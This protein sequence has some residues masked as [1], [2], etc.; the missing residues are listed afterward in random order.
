MALIIQQLAPSSTLPTDDSALKASMSALKTSI[1][2]LESSINT[3][4]ARSDFWETFGW[5]CAIAVG[6]GVA[7]EIVIIVWDFIEDRHAWRRGIVRAP[8]HPSHVRFWFDIIATAVVII[9]II[10]EAGASG[11]VSSIN[12]Q[13]RSKSSELRAKSD[14]LL[15]LVTQ[16]S[17]DAAKSAHDARLD[18][19]QARYDLAILRSLVSGRQMRPLKGLRLKGKL[20]YVESGDA[21]EA[22]SFCRSISAALHDIAGIATKPMCGSTYPLSDTVVRGPSLPESKTLAKALSEATHFRFKALPN[23]SASLYNGL[24]VLVGPQPPFTIKPTPKRQN[25]NPA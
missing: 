24:R 21:E 17:G 4:G 7:G 5:C 1:S 20:V 11:K 3:L 23:D 16:E 25:N 14:Q 18:A 6:I 8:D 12:S 9:G 13:L 15:A 22:K 2:T 10:L 19:D